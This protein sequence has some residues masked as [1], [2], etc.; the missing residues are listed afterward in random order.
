MQQVS[1]LLAAHSERT[2]SCYYCVDHGIVYLPNQRPSSISASD[3]ESLNERGQNRPCMETLKKLRG[4]TT[5]EPQTKDEAETTMI[6]ETESPETSS[7]EANT[8]GGDDTVFLDVGVSAIVETEEQN[9]EE[10]ASPE[11]E[12]DV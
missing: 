2:R 7:A 11:T 4:E 5:E 1:M 8:D 6:P 3:W 12:I 9:A 10:I